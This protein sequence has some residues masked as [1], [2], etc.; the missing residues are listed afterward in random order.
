MASLFLT[1]IISC[2]DAVS[3]L[4]R[5]QNVIGLTQQQRAEITQVIRQTIPSCPVKIEKNERT[6]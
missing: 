2:S 3:L 1:T 5:V 6:K 4:N